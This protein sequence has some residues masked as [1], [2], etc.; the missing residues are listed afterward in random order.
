MKKEGKVYEYH[1]R[2]R[3]LSQG[4]RDGVTSL[5][6]EHKLSVNNKGEETWRSSGGAR[7]R[8]WNWSVFWLGRE[9]EIIPDCSFQLVWADLIYFQ[10]RSL[11]LQLCLPGFLMSQPYRQIVIVQFRCR[12]SELGLFSPESP[13][14][15]SFITA[16][17]LVELW[18]MKKVINFHAR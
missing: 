2:R 4:V 8:P 14:P 12:R 1:R 10:I 9:R 17:P 18:R 15:G 13:L 11:S 3:S 7:A 16:G 6:A 5:R